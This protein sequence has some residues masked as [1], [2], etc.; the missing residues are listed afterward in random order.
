MT[1]I[2]G[3]SSFY[4]DSAASLISDGVILS[5]VQE[6]RFTRVKHDASFPINS[7]KW[8]LKTNSLKLEDI[9]YIVFYDKPF[10]KFDRLVET[11]IDQA[12]F[13][14]K[15]FKLAMPIWLKEKLFLK[16]HLIKIFKD[17]FQIFNENKLKFCEHHL[18][19]AASAYYP[20]PFNESI[21]LTLDGVGE[22]VTSSV[23]IGKNK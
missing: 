10:I 3:I 4:H 8:I 16:R 18:S 5:A 13:G 11:Y 12:P 2:L 23:A 6:E 14:F 20:S 15:S 22:W 21:I 7:I 17:N 9:D 1:L 19:H